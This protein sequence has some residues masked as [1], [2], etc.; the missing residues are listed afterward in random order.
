MIAEFV[1][2]FLLV[3]GNSEPIFPDGVSAILQ[4]MNSKTPTTPDDKPK[5]DA[6]SRRGS[7]AL[8]DAMVEELVQ[9]DLAKAVFCYSVLSPPCGWYDSSGRLLMRKRTSR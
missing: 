8:E 9:Q 4:T 5:V 2:S 7:H 6:L 3:V 1:F